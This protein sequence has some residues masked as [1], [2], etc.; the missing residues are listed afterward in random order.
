M[1]TIAEKWS[2]AGSEGGRDETF[3]GTEQRNPKNL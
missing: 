3:R 1:K 2:A